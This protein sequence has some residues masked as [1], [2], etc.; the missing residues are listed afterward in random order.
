MVL[1]LCVEA[2]SGA[3]Q[4]NLLDGRDDYAIYSKLI[5]CREPLCL[6]ESSTVPEATTVNGRVRADIACVSAPDADRASLTEIRADYDRRKGVSIPFDRRFTLQQPYLLMV[7]VE[8]EQFLRDASMAAPQILPPGG[9]IPPNAN[10]LASKASRVFRLGNV[11]FDQART[12][13]LVDYAEYQTEY[14]YRGGWQV[15]KK[16]AD[17]QWAP[18]M[19]WRTCMWGSIR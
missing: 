18:A 10:P 6:I 15:F 4:Q 1:A 16:A 13:A 2:V 12:T 3:P 19:G 7:K 8:V 17:G 11:F 5:A 14:D 9:S